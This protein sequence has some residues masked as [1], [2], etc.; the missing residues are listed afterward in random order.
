MRQGEENAAVL[1]KEICLRGYSGGYGQVN[2]WVG[3]HRSFSAPTTA[4]KHLRVN[5]P[6]AEQVYMSQRTAQ[7]LP[8]PRQLAWLLTTRPDYLNDSHQELFRRISQDVEADAIIRLSRQYASLI[9]ASCYGQCQPLGQ[10]RT[11]LG[12]WLTEAQQS[13]VS[14]IK[15]FAESLQQDAPAVI[16]ALTHVHSSAQMEGQ[17]T[18]IKLLKRQMYGRASFDLLRRRV[19]LAV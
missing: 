18:R 11:R 17:N 2:R 8:T 14:D 7:P 16:A 3:L 9:R 19:L 5:T 6:T 15:T 1:F 4:K 12:H 10:A 13:A